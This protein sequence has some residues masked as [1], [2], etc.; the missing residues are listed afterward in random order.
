MNIVHKIIYTEFTKD[1]N[2]TYDCNLKIKL[3]NNVIK[4]LKWQLKMLKIFNVL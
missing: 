2:I 4:W 3:L 1:K